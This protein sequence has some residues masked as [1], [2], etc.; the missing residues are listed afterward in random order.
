MSTGRTAEIFTDRG[1]IELRRMTAVDLMK[2][3]RA[4]PG[5]SR[6]AVVT[7]ADEIYEAD[8]PKGPAP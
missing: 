1:W 7:L 3:S 5:A 4:L 2:A 8:R 6:S